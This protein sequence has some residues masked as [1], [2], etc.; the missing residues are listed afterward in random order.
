MNPQISAAHSSE[1]GSE[2]IEFLPLLRDSETDRAGC[3]EMGGVGD[4]LG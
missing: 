2:Q 4:S 1:D 3:R